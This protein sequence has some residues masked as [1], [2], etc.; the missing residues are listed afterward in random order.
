MATGII[1][2]TKM[3][4]GSLAVSA[5]PQPLIASDSTPGGQFVADGTTF[6]KCSR[7]HFFADPGNSATINFGSK[8]TQNGVLANSDQ[9]GFMKNVQRPDL[10]YF[11]GTPGDKVQYQLEI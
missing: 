9:K 11:T 6:P 7:I 3:L 2:S 10:L 4:C 5:T 8:G 1:T